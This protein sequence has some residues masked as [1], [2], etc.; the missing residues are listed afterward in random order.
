MSLSHIKYVCLLILMVIALPMAGAKPMA[1]AETVTTSPGELDLTYDVKINGAPTDSILDLMEQSSR[2]KQLS[3]K[4][5]PSYAALRRRAEVDVEGFE[6]VLRSEGYY[7]NEVEL[8]IDNNQQ[9]IAITFDITPGPLFRITKFDIHFSQGKDIPTAP[10]LSDLGIEIGMPARSEPVVDAGTQIVVDLANRGYPDATV[11]KQDAI[12]DFA[13]DAMEVT[14]TIDAG[15]RLY[16]G[17]LE[18]EG[19][20]KVDQEYIRRLAEWQPGKLYD[21]RVIDNLRRRYLRSGLFDSVRV[22]SREKDQPDSTVPITLVFV[23]RDR[24]SVGLGASYST[25]EGFGTQYYWENRNYFGEGEKIRADLTIAEIRRELKLT[26]V[27]PNFVKIDQNLNANFDIRNETTDA[28]DEEAVSAFIGLDRRWRK[29]WVVGAGVSVE[30][31]KIDDSGV[32]ENYALGGLP[33]TARYNSTNDLLDPTKGRRFGASLVPYLGLN[34][35][36]PDFI[37]FEMD[38]STYYSVLENDRLVLAARGKLGLMAGDSAGA[39]PANKRFYSGGGGSV[40]GY[41]Y[42]TVGP[43]DASNDPIGGRSLLEVGFEARTR[44][45][46]SIG[47]VPFIEGGNVYESMA[48]DFSGEFLWGAGLGF[49]YYTAIGP[50]RFDVAVPLNPRKNVDDPYQFYI[51]IGQAF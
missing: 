1:A 22:K 27:K 34:E 41:Q 20:E 29:K 44:I 51:S 10:T 23:E 24:R 17:E 33:L 31:A 25:S 37:R 3:D 12:V 2:L 9:P 26:F 35:N 39:I 18:L 14:L 48:P 45:T 4:L 11:A 21:N 49:R 42:Q 43:L 46:D 36:T 13:T 7:A 19:L 38:G 50:I 32:T 6:K 30:Y 5:P 8:R 47:I 28:Y 16:M 15:P 40:R